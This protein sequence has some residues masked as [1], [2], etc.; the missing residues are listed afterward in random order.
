MGVPASTSC[1]HKSQFKNWVWWQMISQTV[2]AY[3]AT[4]AD[5]GNIVSMDGR[6]DR[7]SIVKPV[8][9]MKLSCMSLPFYATECAGVAL[10]VNVW[11]SHKP[12]RNSL[13]SSLVNIPL[14]SM[15]SHV[16]C[17]ATEFHYIGIPNEFVVFVLWYS[18]ADHSYM[19]EYYSN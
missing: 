11:E 1:L 7:F 10:N 9:W 3:Q 13:Y 12:S 2:T 19:I 5:S 16:K 8:G 6:I 14:I 17:M 15:A 18:L 4:V